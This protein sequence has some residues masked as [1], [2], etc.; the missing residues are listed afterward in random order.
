MKPNCYDCKS[1]VYKPQEYGVTG[2]CA[3]KH[4]DVPLEPLNASY[5]EWEEAL[6]TPSTRAT[7]CPD[8]DLGERQ[9]F[10]KEL[11]ELEREIAGKME[12]WNLMLEGIQDYDFAHQ[13]QFGDFAWGWFQNEDPIDASFIKATENPNT[14][15]KSIK[16]VG[17]ETRGPH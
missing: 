4:F 7:I 14:V 6:G 1:C 16:S 12:E 13:K 3:E 8:F 17:W 5:H 10:C 15:W 11:K 2:Q 9:K